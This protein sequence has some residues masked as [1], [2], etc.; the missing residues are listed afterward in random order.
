MSDWVQL[1][2]L[3]LVTA[4]TAPTPNPSPRTAR[5]IMPHLYHLLPTPHTLHK[6]QLLCRW[7]CA[8]SSSTRL[9]DLQPA[10]APAPRR[11]LRGRAPRGRR[12]SGPRGAENGAESGGTAAGGG[13]AGGSSGWREDSGERG[14][15]IENEGSWM[16]WNEVGWHALMG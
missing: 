11:H 4:A 6:K 13:A 14:R 9:G 1:K 3:G 16:S 5:Q 8:M 10:A 15:R 2:K 7:P 12:F